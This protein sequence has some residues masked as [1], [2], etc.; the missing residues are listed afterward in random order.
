MNG[1]GHHPHRLMAVCAPQFHPLCLLK[2]IS[3]SLLG[4]DNSILRF[5]PGGGGQSRAAVI[6]CALRAAA[7]SIKCTPLVLF[8][9]A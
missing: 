4:V 2:E 9:H 7:N 6:I 5:R 3:L 8:S 1:E